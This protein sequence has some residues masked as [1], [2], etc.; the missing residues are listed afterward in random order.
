MT[1]IDKL[2]RMA[3]KSK[4]Y[5]FIATHRGGPLTKLQHQQLMNWGRL[6]MI[7]VIGKT[8]DVLD[9]KLQLA[10]TISEQLEKGNASVGDARNAAFGAH[11][12]ARELADDLMVTIARGLGHMVA[13]AH[14]AD[15]ALKAADFALKVI[16]FQQGSVEH[17]REWQNNQL[18]AEIKDL[19]MNERKK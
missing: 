19:V 10:I 2:K 7:H 17:E 9:E 6:C 1:G 8:G 14:M 13:T 18:P 5:N 15:H 12:V 11:S 4:R 3:Q 16:T